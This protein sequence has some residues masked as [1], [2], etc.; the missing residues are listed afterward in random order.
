MPHSLLDFVAGMTVPKSLDDQLPHI[1]IIRLREENLDPVRRGDGALSYVLRGVK[2]DGVVSDCYVS[3]G[4]LG[5][6]KPVL[7]QAID[8]LPIPPTEKSEAEIRVQSRREK[9]RWK[10]WDIDILRVVA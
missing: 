5:Y 7:K 6:L 8:R 2:I 4:M 10:G 1:V 3:E 9:G